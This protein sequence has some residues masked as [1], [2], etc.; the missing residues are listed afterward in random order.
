MIR[1]VFALV[2]CT[3]A[4]TTI[5]CAQ[6]SFAEKHV[7]VSLRMIGHQLLLQVGDSTSRVLSVTRELDHYRMTFE[8]DFAVAPETLVQVV[9]Q[10][11]KDQAIAT[12]YILEVEQC[13]TEEVAYSFEMDNLNHQVLVACQGRSLPKAC[14]NLLFTLS[15]PLET[16]EVNDQSNGTW[17]IK[18]QYVTIPILILVVVL[19]LLIWR[20]RN[21]SSADPNRIKLGKFFFDR[22][23]TMLIM[24]EQKIE[25]TGKEAD[26]L[27]ILY[28][29]VNET[30]KKEDLLNKVWGDEGDYIGRT[31]DVFISKL[32]K[33]F[34]ADPNVRIVNVRGVGYKL[35][36]EE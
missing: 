34:E 17:F 19:S 6:E 10:V 14:Y 23:S 3:L 18:K 15:G 26:L 9:D 20:K 35:V 36:I 5:L 32:R 12:H 11:M 8:S 24:E 13:Q 27:L 2:F 1:S 29:S 33:K 28:D 16:I 4:T 31:L 25:L 22:R 7:K 30:V 21:S